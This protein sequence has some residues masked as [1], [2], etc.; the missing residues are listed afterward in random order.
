MEKNVKKEAW[1]H[2]CVSSIGGFMGAYAIINHCDLL[3]SSQTSNMI[4]IV[5]NLFEPEHSLLIYMVLAALVYA[6]GNVTYV[7]LHKFIKLDTKIISLGLTSVTFI[8]VSVL[9]FVE[10]SY[11]AML[12]LFFAAPIQWNA[13]AGDAG[14]GSSTIF[15][16]NNIRQTVTS[17]TSY[18]IDGDIK[19]KRKAQFFG[20]TL[21]FFHIGVALASVAEFFWA[22]ESIWLG[23]LP[24]AVSAVCCMWYK[25]VKVFSFVKKSEALE[26]IVEEQV[27]I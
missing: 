1:L 25:E 7:L 27:N 24:L 22:R 13:Y 3:A 16:T 10:N 21:I 18:L 19:M 17:L 23:F 20:M 12:P 6:C 5:H 11:L 9:N 8:L 26:S 4:H 15:S 14:Y 2:F